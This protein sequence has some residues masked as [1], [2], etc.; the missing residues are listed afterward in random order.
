MSRKSIFDAVRRMLGR[1]YTASEVA[2]LD[3]AIDASMKPDP[4]SAPELPITPKTIGGAGLALI[5]QFEGCRLTAYPD[6]GSGGDPWTIGFGATGPGIAR[7]VVWTQAQAD[8]RLEADVAEFAGGVARVLGPALERTSQ[9]Q[10]DALVSFAFNC[11]MENLRRST[12]LAKHK[13]GNFKGA[14]A[15][16]GRWNRAAGRVLA[17][18]TRRRSAESALYREG[19]R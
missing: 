2:A 8:A 7:G 5:K 16:F 12:L 19:S 14:A 15:E 6:P 13:A 1:G 18:L 4:P 3:A 11:G 17:G 10:F 9:S